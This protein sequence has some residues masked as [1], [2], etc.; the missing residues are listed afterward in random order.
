MRAGMCNGT[1]VAQVLRKLV[2]VFKLLADAPAAPVSAGMD[3]LN[4]HRQHASPQVMLPTPRKPLRPPH[5]TLPFL[6]LEPS[7]FA[8]P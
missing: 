2:Q 4:A 3:L 6:L 1:M 7:T 5:H 8:F